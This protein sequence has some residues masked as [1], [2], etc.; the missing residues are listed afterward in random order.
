MRMGEQTL[1]HDQ[2]SSVRTGRSRRPGKNRPTGAI[3]IERGI[4]VE[5]AANVGLEVNRRIRV[6]QA[7]DPN[8]VWTDDSAGTGR[9][10]SRTSRHGRRFKRYDHLCAEPTAGDFYARRRAFHAVRRQRQVRGHRDRSDRTQAVW[11]G[12]SA[13]L[14]EGVLPCAHERA[15]GTCAM[16]QGGQ[17]QYTEAAQNP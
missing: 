17:N 8:R 15:D 12:W 9:A 3:L 13:V 6:E 2:A 7:R 5:G 14:R 10:F 1:R 4:S 11:S 16:H